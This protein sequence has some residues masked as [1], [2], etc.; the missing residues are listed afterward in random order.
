MITQ[1]EDTLNNSQCGYDEQY[2]MFWFAQ[3]FNQDIGGWDVSN[4]QDFVSDVYVYA[5]IDWVAQVYFSFTFHCCC[6]CI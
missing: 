2:G 3:S 4:G 1:E 6:L 5:M